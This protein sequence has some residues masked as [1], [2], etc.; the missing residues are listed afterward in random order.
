MSGNYTT[1]VQTQAL[2][3]N[4]PKPMNGFSVQLPQDEDKAYLDELNSTIRPIL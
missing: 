1:Y 3:K 4:E 2:A